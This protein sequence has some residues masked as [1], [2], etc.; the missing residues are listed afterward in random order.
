MTATTKRKIIGGSLRVVS[1]VV[2]AGVPL[3]MMADKFTLWAATEDTGVALTGMGMVGV[4]FAALILITKIRKLAEPV[5]KFFKRVKGPYMVSL[6]IIGLIW[7]MCVGAQQLYPISGD[8]I[9]LCM[10]SAASVGAGFGMDTAAEF[11][12]PKKKKEE[13]NDK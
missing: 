12:S 9:T 6:I 8:I 7:A 10:G 3:L 2:A 1:P 4:L 11:V 5:V 13:E